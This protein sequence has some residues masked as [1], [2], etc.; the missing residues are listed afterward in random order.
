MAGLPDCHAHIDA[1]GESAREVL[2]EW[3]AAGIGPVIS[4]GIDADS[5]QEGVELA[6]ALRSIKAAVGLHPWKVAEGYTGPGDL[7]VYGDI[8]SD[9]MVVAIS[10]VGLDTTH[11]AKAPLDTQREVLAWFIG[12]AQERGFPVVL[13]LAAPTEA[14]LGTWD[15]VEGRK[16]AA[17]I[18]CFVGTGDDAALLLDRQ[19]YLSLGPY[20]LGLVGDTSVED[21]VIRA[22]PDEK[23][24]V[25]SDAFPAWDDYPEVR[26]T[27][28]GDV[29]RRVAEIRGVDI[30]D[31]QG[32]VALNFEQLLRNQS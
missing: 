24:L 2:A 8:A 21:D 20:S 23:L 7:E 13:H 22:I 9:P 3:D 25:D 29:A 12:L 4:A 6:W 31:L 27:I 28:V 1:F 5:S 32:Q 17:A 14:L 16:P 18:H 19:M 30:A 15:A 10:E 26:P 11:R